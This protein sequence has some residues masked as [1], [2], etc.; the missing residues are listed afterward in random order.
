VLVLGQAE[1]AGQRVEIGTCLEVGIAH[2]K[3]GPMATTSPISSGRHADISSATR[4]RSKS[5]STHCAATNF[6]DESGDAVGIV[7]DPIP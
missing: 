1:G 3:G 5:R 2:N 4:H 6:S 7:A